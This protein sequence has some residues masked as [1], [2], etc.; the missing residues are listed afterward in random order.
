MESNKLYINPYIRLIFLVCCIAGTILIN[1]ILWLIGCYVVII[2]PL[3][4]YGCQTMKHIKLMLFGM[5]PIYLSFILLYIIIL[6]G[7]NGGWEFV[8]LKLLKLVLFTSVI[9]LTL[10][11]PDQ[12]L[13]STFKLWGLKGEALITVLGAFTVWTDVNYR[14]DKIVTARFSRGF[15]KKRTALQKI[16]QFP[17]VLIPLVVGIIRTAT[18]R[19]ESWEQKDI[20]YLVE[21]NKSEKVQSPLF[22]NIGIFV[23]SISCLLL[24]IYYKLYNQ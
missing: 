23:V 1:N 9:Q 3:F 4:L 10:L 14:A 20:M 19:A 24:G 13:I 21:V 15:I 16:K 22:L 2:L 17:Y 18:E 12:Y 5:L 8:N 11:I 7:S 6:N